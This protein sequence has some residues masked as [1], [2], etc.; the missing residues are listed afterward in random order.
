MVNA[1]R[2]EAALGNLEATSLAEQHVVVRHPHVVEQHLGVAMG[3]VVVTE[4]RQRAQHLDPGGIHRHQDHRVLLVARRLR[5]GQAHE[6]HHLAAR[7]AGAGG[8]PLAAV[9]HPLIA[10]A[11]GAGFHVGGIRGGHARLGHGEGRADLAA[12]QRLQPLLLLRL[13]AIAHQHL[14]VAGV[15]RGAVERLGADQR[16]AHDLGQRRV[17]G[18]A[19]PGAQLGVRQEQVPQSRRLRL[20]LEL[21]HDRGWLPAVALRHLLLEHGLGR[22]D[23]ILHE[24]GDAFTQ[25]LDLGGVGEIH[26]ELPSDEN[27]ERS[28]AVKRMLEQGCGFI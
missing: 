14:H 18:V 15:R 22:V 11:H 16:A 1:T 19:Q 7:V 26:G 25:I 8:P 9:D 13:V 4:H 28:C 21:F 17:L 24:R 5:V 27:V 6:D 12:E 20:G 2:A 3:G 10:L 23:M